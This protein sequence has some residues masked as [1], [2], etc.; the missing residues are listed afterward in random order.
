[1][2]TEVTRNDLYHAG[3]EH[4]NASPLPDGMMGEVEVRRIVVTERDV[5]VARMRSMF[6]GGSTAIRAGEYVGLY[7]NGSLW[8]SDTP[9]EQYD[10]MPVI[11]NVAKHR[12]ERVL[13]N[14]LGIGMVLNAVLHMDC[15]QHVD[16]VEIDPDVVALVGPHYAELAEANGKTL[17]IHTD[18]A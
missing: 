15:V 4:L 6:G 13:I 8:M 16:V 3:R 2:V 10:H 1:M 7:R 11:T 14:G 5:E 17:T 18:G 9:D 12:A